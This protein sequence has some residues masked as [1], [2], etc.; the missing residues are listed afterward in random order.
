MMPS[1]LNNDM[2]INRYG[3]K[4]TQT[5]KAAGS[6]TIKVRNKKGRKRKQM[7]YLPSVHFWDIERIKYIKYPGN[8]LGI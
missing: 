3:I 7:M 6:F 5:Q 1:N 4:G 8:S 2:V